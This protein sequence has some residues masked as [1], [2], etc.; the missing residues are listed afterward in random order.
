MK[1]HKYLKFIGLVGL[2]LI[3]ACGSSTANNGNG[4]GGTTDTGSTIQ[5]I[6]FSQPDNGPA[7]TGPADTGPVDTG[8][9]DTGPVDTGPAD[10]GPVDTG[11]V[12]TGPTDTGPAKADCPGYAKAYCAKFDTCA[13]GILVGEFGDQATCASRMEK[14]YCNLLQDLP[15]QV[16]VWPPAACA[17]AIASLS[18]GDITGS[19]YLKTGPCK[20]PAGTLIDGQAC[21]VDNQCQAGH[22][23]ASAAAQGCGVCTER[24]AA[25]DTC[26]PFNG[27]D[28]DCAAGLLC[29]S[30]I[31]TD[32]TSS[33]KCVAPAQK[34]DGCSPDKCQPVTPTSGSTNPYTG[35]P[36]S[37]DSDFDCSSY[38]GYQAGLVCNGG[39]GNGSNAGTCGGL[40][41]VQD[42]TCGTGMKCDGTNMLCTLDCSQPPCVADAICV[43][44]LCATP[45]ATN[46]TCEIDTATGISNCNGLQLEACDETSHTCVQSSTTPPTPA[47]DGKPCIVDWDGSDNCLWPATCVN[48]ACKACF[49]R[50]SH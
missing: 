28:D 18:C 12:D 42:S 32:G 13:H 5:D 36:S 47:A 9:V 24:N 41:C 48:N 8:P 6:G 16:G 10:T 19:G 40:F 45:V 25:G 30:T 33:A 38:E 49:S 44:N 4:A 22:C 14:E 1:D 37:C 29:I 39:L 34:G 2:A 7:D 23:K 46:G 17:G 35:A 31:A 20:M 27:G 3:L 26:D 15:G 11:P 50:T 21:G 43:K